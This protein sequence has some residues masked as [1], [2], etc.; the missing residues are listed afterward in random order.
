MGATALDVAERNAMVLKHMGLVKH[1][2][3]QYSECWIELDDL[4]QAGI[5]GLMHGIEKYD[6]SKGWKIS[7]YVSWWIRN[8]MLRTINRDRNIKIPENLYIVAR[9]VNKICDKHYKKTGEKLSVNDAIKRVKTELS[10][11]TISV[12]V[13]NKMFQTLSFDSQMYCDNDRLSI[14]DIM[15]DVNAESP[16]EAAI[17]ESNRK[18]MK[19]A[20]TQLKPRERFVIEQRFY[21][22]KTLQNIADKLGLSRER[23]RQIEKDALGDLRQYLKGH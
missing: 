11:E 1:I 10:N 14:L 16:A 7:T 12:V 17:K 5:I 19:T 4:I 3:K 13:E 15:P 9:R 21:H 6:P 22:D 8:A 18:R 23:I 20:L 2:A